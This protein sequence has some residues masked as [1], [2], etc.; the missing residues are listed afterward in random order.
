MFGIEDELHFE[1]EKLQ[2]EN[3]KLKTALI[4]FTYMHRPGC[5]LKELVAQRGI[6]SDMTIIDSEDFANAAKALD[7]SPNKEDYN[8]AYNEFPQKIYELEVKLGLEPAAI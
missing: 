2:E 4:P 7:V 8:D 1:I 5:N 3:R 6:S